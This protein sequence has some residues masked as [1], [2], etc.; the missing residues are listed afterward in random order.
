MRTTLQKS[1]IV[2]LS[3]QLLTPF[4]QARAGSTFAK[5]GNDWP[6]YWFTC[7]FANRNRAPEDHCKMFDDE[8]FQ[9]AEDRHC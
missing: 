9:L 2:L 8:G 4:Q 6:G 3:I 5:N 7:E 1:L